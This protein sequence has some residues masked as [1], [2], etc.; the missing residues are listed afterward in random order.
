MA[1]ADTIG[2]FSVMDVSVEFN[3]AVT[4]LLMRSINASQLPSMMN[5]ICHIGSWSWVLRKKY[6]RNN[7][8]H[9]DVPRH[10][11]L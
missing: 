6:D 7:M 4:H 8:S 1:P 5:A 3:T 2:W 11:I 10:S 9:L